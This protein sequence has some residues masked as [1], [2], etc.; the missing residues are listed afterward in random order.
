MAKKDDSE[1]IARY[2][3][4]LSAMPVYGELPNLA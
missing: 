2:A 4:M 1:L 3:D